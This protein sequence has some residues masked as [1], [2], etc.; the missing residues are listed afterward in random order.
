MFSNVYSH[1]ECATRLCR[2]P[3]II[4]F[5]CQLRTT[6]ATDAGGLHATGKCLWNFAAVCVRLIFSILHVGPAI[7]VSSRRGR[8]LF[9]TYSLDAA[10]DTGRMELCKNAFVRSNLY[11]CMCHSCYGGYT[12]ELMSGEAT[13]ERVTTAYTWVPSK[14]KSKSKSLAS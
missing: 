14:S 7:P 13:K 11:Y 9:P 8:E 3:S 12:Q 1:L 5:M 2:I 6:T 10:V 4:T